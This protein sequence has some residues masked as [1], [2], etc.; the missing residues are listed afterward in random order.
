VAEKAVCWCEGRKNR[1]TLVMG[2]DL[3]D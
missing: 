1:R 3:R 2:A